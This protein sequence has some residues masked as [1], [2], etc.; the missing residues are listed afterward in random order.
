MVSA[1]RVLEY[2]QLPQEAAWIVRPTRPQNSAQKP[3][4]RLTFTNLRLR[5][6]AGLKLALKG[7][8]FD[9]QSKEKIGVVVGQSF[10][11]G[12]FAR[13]LGLSPEPESERDQ[14]PK[15]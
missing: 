2:T 7:V 6:R 13:N 14:T 9:V 3:Q 5:Y 15:S 1:E 11:V 10:C 4:G 8:T 12:T